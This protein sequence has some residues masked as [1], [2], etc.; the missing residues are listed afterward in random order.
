MAEYSI[1]VFRKERHPAGVPLPGL[2]NLLL[3]LLDSYFDLLKK[4]HHLSIDPL[5]VI[6]N[7]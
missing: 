5:K 2:I 7:Y 1:G 4:T 3:D 6:D